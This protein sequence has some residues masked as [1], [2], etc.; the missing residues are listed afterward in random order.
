M[1]NESINLKKKGIYDFF[2]PQKVQDTGKILSYFEQKGKITQ[3]DIEETK[4]LINLVRNNKPSVKRA[5]SYIAMQKKG[6]EKQSK[7]VIRATDVAIS[8][9]MF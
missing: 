5:D 2:Q 7:K 9:A 4:K 8:S 3:N 1:I 6:G